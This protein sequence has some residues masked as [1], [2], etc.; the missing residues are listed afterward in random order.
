MY[1]QNIYLFFTKNIEIFEYSYRVRFS[2]IIFSLQKLIKKIYS[3]ILKHIMR[4]ANPIQP[5]NINFQKQLVAKA[6]IVS[7]GGKPKEVS[8]YHLD[9]KKDI[10]EL[11]HAYND[12]SWK[13][14]YYLA[15]VLAYFEDDYNK[16]KYYTME[17]DEQNILCYSILNETNR[18]RNRLDCIETIPV[19]SS[20][21]EGKR[22][23]KYIG[24]TMLAFLAKE[25]RLQG[26]DFHILSIAKRQKTQNFYFNQCRFQP[27]GSDDALVDFPDLKAF[28]VQNERHTGGKIRL[29]S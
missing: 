2:G 22:D 6:N 18:K 16:V 14:N 28:I 8:I 25:T 7:K 4:I 21:T 20:Y 26:K 17:D 15:S 10:K 13:G 1:V 27:Y 24:E 23:F 19:Q 11:E 3:G 29:M 9:E 12:A 5:F